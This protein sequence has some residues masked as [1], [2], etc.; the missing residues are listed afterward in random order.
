MYS[1]SQ[2]ESL[3]SLA[4]QSILS[5]LENGMALKV[6]LSDYDQALRELRASFVTLHSEGRLR[7]CIGTL[8]AHRALAE[9]VAQNAYAAA[10]RDP[11]FDPL[12]RIEFDDLQL[13]VSVL[14]PS[15]ELTFNSEQQLLAQLQ[16]GKDG[17]V[18]E[19]GLHKGTFLPAVWEQLPT[20]EVFLQHLK[21]KAGLSAD[22]WSDNI[23]VSRYYTESF[24]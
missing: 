22:Y 10:F 19:D 15:T 2:R 4:R 11:R 23:R 7:G 13:G 20:A 8:E 3:L 24:E 12:Q 5:G 18:L 14:T 17:L 16:P 21:I 9:D 1:S 6:T